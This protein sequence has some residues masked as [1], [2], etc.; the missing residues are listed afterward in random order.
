LL[1]AKERSLSWKLILLTTLV[2][3]ADM[4]TLKADPLCAIHP[5]QPPTL[6][7]LKVDSVEA[8]VVW[9]FAFT[10]FFPTWQVPH[11]GEHC[12]RSLEPKEGLKQGRGVVGSVA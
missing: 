12:Y 11:F 9:L 6:E 10:S 1:L 3:V 2:L 4:S 7:Q 8:P 5:P